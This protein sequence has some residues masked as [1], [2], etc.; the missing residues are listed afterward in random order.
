MSRCIYCRSDLNKNDPPDDM[1]QSKEHIVPY[2]I[3]GSD[4][5]TTMDVSKRYNNDFGRDIDAKFVNLLP[6][7]IKRHMLQIAGQSGKIP[8][9]IW[10][11]RSLDN[12]ESST[13]TLH[14]DGRVD[15]SFDIATKRVEKQ[16]HEEFAVSGSADKVIE[17]LSG[18]LAKSVKQGK[19]V[20]TVSGEEI[21]SMDDFA[22][23]YEIEES[24]RFG[25]SI[26]AFDFDIWTRG[27]FKMILGLGHL[28]LGPEWTFSSDGGDRIRTV[29]ATNRQDWPV[30][31]VKGFSTGELPS[32]IAHLLGITAEVR[33]RNRH[34]LAILPG[35]NKTLAAVSLFGGDGVPEALVELGGE[36]GNL[37]VV[38]DA[39][40]ATARIGVHIDPVNRSV[41]WIT[42]KDLVNAT[43]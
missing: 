43:Y 8:P 37:A 4:A 31:S 18:K 16:T 1:T 26:R 36:T 12:N 41:E 27:I 38:N 13:I 35:D 24:D 30:H 10:A 19:T 23:H 33:Q 42:V 29:L 9:I 11:A 39:M 17:I 25:A 34:T 20:Y 28:V 3:G 22:K 32:E 6:V 14:A 40:R 5:F 2:A 15:C 21:R 7:S